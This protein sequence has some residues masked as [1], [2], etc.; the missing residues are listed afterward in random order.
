M[1]LSNEATSKLSRPQQIF[2]AESMGQRSQKTS[3][4]SEHLH[5]M[6]ETNEFNMTMMSES[7]IAPNTNPDIGVTQIRDNMHP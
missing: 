3:K 7:L 1:H 2:T 5:K 6:S 4:E